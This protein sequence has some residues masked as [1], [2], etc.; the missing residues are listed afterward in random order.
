MSL[1][2]PKQI[3]LTNQRL[4]FPPGSYNMPMR[5]ERER[6]TVYVRISRPA[7][8]FKPFF[9]ACDAKRRGPTDSPKDPPDRLRARYH[10]H[11]PRGD[12]ASRASL[13]PHLT[14][15]THLISAD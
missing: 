13:C 5:L 11:G 1:L 14:H 2:S 12:P 10:T 4:T 7:G 3:A 6:Y 15:E 9:T 8:T